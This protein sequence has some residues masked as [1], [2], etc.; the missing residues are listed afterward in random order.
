MAISAP[1]TIRSQIGMRVRRSSDP[2]ASSSALQAVLEL[3]PT[4][5]PAE[6]R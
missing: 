4:G 5:A 6:R 1:F 2:V 3:L